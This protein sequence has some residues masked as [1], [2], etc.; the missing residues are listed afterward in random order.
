MAFADSSMKSSRRSPSE[1]GD[2]LAG[3]AYVKTYV[4][5]IH[6]VERLYEAITTP[7]H[8]HVAESASAAARH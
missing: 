6:Y 4:E 7:A 3:R 2:V 8:G 5:F 1:P